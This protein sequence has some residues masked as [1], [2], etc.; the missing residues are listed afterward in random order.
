MDR[1]V[2]SF[3]FAP[4]CGGRPVASQD[5]RREPQ[6]FTCR[7]GILYP[8]LKM[9][10]INRPKELANLSS[11]GGKGVGRLPLGGLRQRTSVGHTNG[12]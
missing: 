4:R 10:S 1:S 9:Q 6:G 3:R 11:E 7:T 5:R 8:P 12:T 2:P